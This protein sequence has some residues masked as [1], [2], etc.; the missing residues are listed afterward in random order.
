MSRS[1]QLKRLGSRLEPWMVAVP[2]VLVVGGVTYLVASSI[3]GRGLPA[4]VVEPAPFQGVPFAAG[5][6][7]PAWPVI[8]SNPRFGVVSYRDVQ[9]NTHG[10]ASRRFGA[11]RDDRNHAGVDIY[12][13]AGDPV[14]AMGK[15]TVV[16]T[17]TFHLGSHAIFVDHGDVTV[18]YGE[19]APRSWQEFGLGVGSKVR[20]GDPIARIDCMVGEVGDCRSHMLHLETYRPGTTKNQ[21]WYRGNAAPS[22]LLDPTRLL[23]QAQPPQVA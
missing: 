14:V 12:A 21:R 8:T 16:A 13:N 5:I 9:G 17:Q 19:V 4:G 6:R 2:A 11:N 18:M 10:N 22:Q 7:R 20:K 15:G 23:L 3:L 1:G